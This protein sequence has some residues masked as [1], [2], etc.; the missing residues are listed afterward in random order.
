MYQI[1][2]I[3]GPSSV[4]KTTL[5]KALQE[6]LDEPFL[7]LGIDRMIAMMPEKMNNWEGESA[8][9][10][11][12]FQKSVDET[13]AVV[14]KVVIGPFAMKVVKAHKELVRCLASLGHF[15]IIDDVSF[16]KEQVD[17]WKKA[18]KDY[19]VLWI[20][21]DAPLATLEAREL[22]RNNR[23]LGSA[24]EQKAKVHTDVTYDLFFD[25]ST[26]SLKDCVKAIIHKIV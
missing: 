1:L 8:P 6:A 14:Q 19:R 17:Q 2:Y 18:L 15:V 4:G 9:L 21:L 23:M 10:G 3:N 7:H 20:G 25:T 12:A 22:Q 5:I 24:R 16:G 13:G 26:T 11:F